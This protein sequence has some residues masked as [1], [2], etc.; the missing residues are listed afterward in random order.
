MAEDQS[1]LSQIRK[2]DNSRQWLPF[3]TSFLL[4]FLVV[5]FV[6]FFRGGSFKLYASLFFSIYFV[7]HQIWLSVLFMGVLQNIIFL[8]LRLI[9]NVLR[10]PLND[11]ENELDQVEEKQ[12]SLVFSKKIKDGNLAI[13]FYIFNFFVN[14]IAFFSAGRIFLID[15]YNKPVSHNLLYNW[16]PY[17]QYP[18]NGT[19]F[20]FPFLKI[21]STFALPWTTIFMII[22]GTIL[23]ST[24]LRLIWRLIRFIFKRNQKILYARIQY[25][26]L[27]LTIG[28]F[29]GVLIL[30]SLFFL[31]HIPNAFQGI[32]LI[33]D[34]TRQNTPMNFV[35][36]VGTFITTIH[37]GYKNNSLAASQARVAGIAPE[38]VAKVFK[39]KMRKSVKNGLI[40][41][42]GAFFITNQIPSAFELSIATFEVMYII[43]PYT[44]GKL[45]SV[46]TN[47]IKNINPQNA[48]V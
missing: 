10:Q 16:V 7:T 5:L 42:A 44:F 3:I 12:Q 27:L 19:D 25:N 29:G 28:G 4:I 9:G 45:I 11:F 22:G 26:R 40:L 38:I 8:P 33:V 46:S 18:L 6:W 48:S 31:R 2:I 41:G 34:L 36:A 43:Y 20:R 23:F 15:F 17:P 35:T 47:K 24:I 37:A 14:A 21:T 1:S 39:E 32:L 13:V 30:A